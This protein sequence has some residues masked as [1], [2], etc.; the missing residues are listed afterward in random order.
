[1]PSKAHITYIKGSI[2]V[3]ACTTFIVQ[4]I[5]TPITVINPTTPH[6]LLLL[7]PVC[8]VTSY[9]KKLTICIS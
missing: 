6:T 3:G 2:I 1:M 9:F 4:Y 8:A 5:R 7:I